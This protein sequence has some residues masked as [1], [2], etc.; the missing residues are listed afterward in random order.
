MEYTIT[1]WPLGL[2]TD[3][4]PLGVVVVAVRTHEV[5]SAAKITRYVP[6]PVSVELE[7]PFAWSS[8]DGPAYAH[9]VA[10]AGPCGPCGPCG[11]PGPAGPAAPVAPCGPA[12]PA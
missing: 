2:L 9:A 3:P 12:G 7:T 8:P 11:P 10:G 5:T 6:A 4:E 1:S